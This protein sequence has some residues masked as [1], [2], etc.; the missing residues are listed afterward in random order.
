MGC[1]ERVSQS[2]AISR[3]IL[4]HDCLWRSVSPFGAL[5][6]LHDDEPK[7]AE[8]KLFTERTIDT[9]D[10]LVFIQIG[11]MVVL[12]LVV[13]RALSIQTNCV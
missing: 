13:V 4:F 9:N 8:I 6:T 10:P 11:V 3:Q 2:K 7:C 5:D 1:K 12:N